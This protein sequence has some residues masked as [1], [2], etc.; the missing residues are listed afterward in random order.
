MPSAS[1]YGSPTSW[2]YAAVDA[3]DQER[4]RVR[5]AA[6]S[7]RSSRSEH[8]RSSVSKA[9]PPRCR[10]GVAA[11][12]C[13]FLTCR[14]GRR[15]APGARAVAGVSE[16]LHAHFPEHA[17]PAHTH[18]TWT[19]LLVDTGTVRYDLD[20]HQHGA[21]GDR[22]TLLPPHVAA[23]R[24]VGRGRPASASG[25]VYLDERRHRRR[26]DRRG[27]STTRAG[28]T[29]RCAAR[30]TGCTARSTHPGDELEAEVRLAARRRPAAAAARRCDRARRRTTGPARWRHRLRDLLDARRGR[31]RL[32]AGGRPRRSARTR[33]TWCGRSAREFGIP[34]HRYLTGRR[35]DRARRLLL[36]G[37][38]RG[39]RRGRGRA[40]TTRPT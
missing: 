8:A 10:G 11:R 22:V 39:R 14:R 35:L 34:P 33:P 18:A 17:Y 3:A 5:A 32:A 31:G 2:G 7:A 29:R 15:S 16:V 9:M 37:E 28:P 24:P 1:P 6:T 19:L 38:R 36:A 13:T 40:S 21:L 25:S 27:R 26:P 4:G 30:S 23:R 12:S 20:R